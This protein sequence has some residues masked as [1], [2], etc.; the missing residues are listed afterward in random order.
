[1][2]TRSYQRLRALAPP[3]LIHLRGLEPVWVRG[4]AERL[5]EL[6]MILG[7]NAVR[8][9][10][11]DGQVTLSLAH[12]GDTVVLRVVDTGIGIPP[13]DL[14]HIFDR[15]Y[16]GAQARAMRREGTGLG[17]AIA[18]WIAELHGAAL[19]VESRPDQ[20]T[21]CTVRFPALLPPGAGA[22]PEPA[23]SQ[24]ILSSF[25]DSSQEPPLD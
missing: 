9:T 1:V 13:A 4:D 12:D 23:D 10:P 20:G 16:R 22:P 14:P 5:E 24:A 25:S 3:G 11:A 15:F 6:L 19:T 8:Y 7:E 17:L 18:R 21:R 2:L